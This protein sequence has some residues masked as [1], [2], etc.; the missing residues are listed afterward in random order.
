MPGY[1]CLLLTALVSFLLIYVGCRMANSLI[2]TTSSQFTP[3]T[4]KQLIVV[5]V[6]EVH[7]Y[8]LVSN[9]IV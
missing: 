3:N 9:F 8:S 2:S 1:S 4:E 5:F 7:I 6:Q